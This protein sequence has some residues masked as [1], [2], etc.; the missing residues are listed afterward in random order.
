VLKAINR[1]GR[2][3]GCHYF[4]YAAYRT[5]DGPDLII[6]AGFDPHQFQARIT[7]PVHWLKGMAAAHAAIRRVSEGSQK[8]CELP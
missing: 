3:L 6:P 8:P 1:E 2:S 4:Q 7:I 5:T